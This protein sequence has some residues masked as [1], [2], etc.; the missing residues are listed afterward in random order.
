[1]RGRPW[2]WWTWTGPGPGSSPS[3]TATAS[4]SSWWT[5]PNTR[6]G[7]STTTSSPRTW[8]G[9]SASQTEAPRPSRNGQGLDEDGDDDVHQR[10]HAGDVHERGGGRA[11]PLLARRDLGQCHPGRGGGWVDA[12]FG[13]VHVRIGG[14]GHAH[15]CQPGEQREPCT[16]HHDGVE[17]AALRGGDGIGADECGHERQMQEDK[18]VIEGSHGPDSTVRGP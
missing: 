4:P 1:G 14:D 10:E 15:E 6:V 2:G 16:P 12:E 3:S 17:A 11:A 13:V 7:R 5:V 9:R 8:P 18:N